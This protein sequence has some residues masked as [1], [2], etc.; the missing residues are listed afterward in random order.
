MNRRA[1]NIIIA[2]LQFAILLFFYHD[3]IFHANQKMVCIDHDGLKN[4]YMLAYYVKYFSSIFTH[5]GF[6]YPFTEYLFKTDSHPIL[7]IGLALMAKLWPAVSNHV[8]GILNLL[9][10]LQPI[11]TTVILFKIFEHKKVSLIPAGIAAIGIAALSPQFYLLTAGHYSQVYSFFIPLNLLL[12]FRF[13]E[14]QKKKHLWHLSALIFI[15]FLFHAYT[16]A[17]LVMFNFFVAIL[18]VLFKKNRR[19]QALYFAAA[20]IVPV[21]LML[22]IYAFDPVTGRPDFEITAYYRAA[23]CNVFLP[24]CSD[25]L[26]VYQSVFNLS[27]QNAYRWSAIGTYVG[28]TSN[29]FILFVFAHTLWI[30]IRNKNAIK[31]NQVNTLDMIVLLSA[32]F[33]LLYAFGLPTIYD[34][35]FLLGKIPFLSQIIALGRFSFVFYYV[36]TLYATLY[37]VKF[38]DKT[39]WKKAISYAIIAL[40]LFESY[41]LHAYVSSKIPEQQNVFDTHIFDVDYNFKQWKINPENYDAILPIPQYIRYFVPFTRSATLYSEELSLALSMRTGLP[42]MAVFLSRPSVPRAKTVLSFVENPTDPVVQETYKHKKIL[43][44]HTHEFNNHQ[45]RQFMN[46]LD[47]VIF[48]NGKVLVSE[49]NTD[50]YFNKLQDQ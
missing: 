30:V 7:A 12:I 13:F 25:L 29:I 26:Q 31:T 42:I 34:H 20:S 9:L 2:F 17:M 4:Y 36:I 10:L 1:N 41:A 46:H 24:R 8:I 37:F 19:K 45:E 3:I 48:D 14:N 44:V 11:L 28:L 18:L 38:A 15:G 35:G 27:A 43:V 22:I 40:F 33:V 16:G 32:I 39:W 21:I 5:R 49:I 50:A 6:A 47:T 23:F